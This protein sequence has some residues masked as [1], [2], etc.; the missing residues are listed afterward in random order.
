[1]ELTVNPTAGGISI[2]VRF[3]CMNPGTAEAGSSEGAV[4]VI[5][6]EDRRLRATICP[7]GRF[8][9][10][11][12]GSKNGMVPP[13][14]LSEQIGQSRSISWFISGRHGQTDKFYGIQARA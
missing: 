6:F 10:A 1:M 11:P 14:A 3:F 7:S 13:V 9:P 4:R 2:H 8:V 12:I 5:H